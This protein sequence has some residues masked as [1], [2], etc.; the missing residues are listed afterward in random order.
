MSKSTANSIYLL[1]FILLMAAFWGPLGL[2][3]HTSFGLG[4]ASL[5]GAIIVLAFGAALVV[6]VLRRR[7]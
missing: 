3:L 1:L 6:R 7:L 5:G 2:W 4:G